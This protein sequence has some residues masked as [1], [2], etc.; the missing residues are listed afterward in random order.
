MPKKAKKGGRKENS[1]PKVDSN[2]KVVS[3]R[4]KMD[5]VLEILKPSWAEL[6]TEV[7]IRSSRVGQRLLT[8]SQARIVGMDVEWVVPKGWNTL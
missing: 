4:K 6:G 5:T 1:R 3:E 7:A 8:G 2:E